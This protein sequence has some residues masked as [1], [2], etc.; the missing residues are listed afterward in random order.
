MHSQKAED[1]VGLKVHH[2]KFYDQDD[3][4]AEVDRV[5][6]I[7]NGCRLC[8]KYCESFP[9][10]FKRIDD[11]SE[12]RRQE[13]LRA[14][15]ELV[16]RAEENR[17]SMEA[18][19][20]DP[21]KEGLEYAVSA[22]DD[23]PELSAHASDLSVAVIEEVND[24]C[25]QCKMCYV[26]CPY[27]PSDNHEFMLDFPR[28]LLRWKANK[29]KRE[30]VPLQKQVMTRTDLVGAVA[31]KVA[32]L[33]NW[34]NRNKLN[35]ILAEK[36]AGIH[37]DKILPEFSANPF[38]AWWVKHESHRH[39]HHADE[40]EGADG[41]Q[42]IHAE[43]ADAP[44]PTPGK[45][46]LFSTCLG[47]YN[48]PAIARAAVRVLEF[49]GIQITWPRTQ[50]CCGMPFCDTGD[51]PSALANMKQNLDAFAPLVEKGYAIVTLEPSCGL[52]FRQEY[53]QLTEGG[54]PELRAKAEA[55]AA[56]TRDIH[57]YLWQLKKEN[58]LRRE[59]A[60]TF[61]KIK[62][63]I[64]CHMRAQN[65]GFRSR[66]ILKLICEDVEMINECSAHDGTWSMDKKYFEESLRYGKKLFDKVKDGPCDGVCTDCT[67]AANQIKQGTELAAEHPILLLAKAYG[68]EIEN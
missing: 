25:F 46:A 26:K 12:A 56:A 27:T 28:L 50:L 1:Y 40:Q 17:K 52:I 38:P 54:D 29:V 21:S 15:P 32:P 51:M 36:T 11:L 30:G 44:A 5:F 55:V 65:I 49:N 10:L 62:Y 37:R 60:T 4:R 39:D 43:A 8:F 67:L 16:A 66:D 7:C 22:G 2:P 9:I 41:S 24:H 34:A 20:V 58:R 64:P 68:L 18:A 59:F 45:V 23:L 57:E 31:T 61:G 42:D 63:H 35:R 3:L 19:G 14:H 6:D 53:L 47:N 33:V 13:Y 48:K